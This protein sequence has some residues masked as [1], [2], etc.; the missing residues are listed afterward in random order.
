MGVCNENER[1]YD[2]FYRHGVMN[3]IN[4]LREA[5]KEV[6]KSIENIGTKVEES[7]VC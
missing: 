5:I 3:D 1:E 2:E 6:R 4:M 7:E